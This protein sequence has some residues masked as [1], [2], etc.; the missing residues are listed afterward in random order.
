MPKKPQ[1]APKLTAAQKRRAAVQEH[2][3]ALRDFRRYDHRNQTA[4]YRR[5]ANRLE[6][7]ERALPWWHRL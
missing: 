5:A 3:A 6:D 2:R 1:N 4:A 7:A